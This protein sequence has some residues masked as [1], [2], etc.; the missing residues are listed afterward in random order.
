MTE[1]ATYTPGLMP[2]D[3]DRLRAL[4]GA[5]PTGV[6]VV[7]TVDAAGV[8]KGLTTQSF[9]AV[10]AEPP[11]VLVTLERS[12]RTL[13]P[14]RAAKA[15]VVNFLKVGAEEIA[16]RFASKIEDKFEGVAWRP[17][18]FARGAPILETA[19]VAYAECLVEREIEAGDHWIFIAVVEGGE[20]LG[21]T[22]LLYYHR[23]YAAWPQ[24]KP[25]P[26]ESW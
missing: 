14:L 13:E 2:V 23:A 19:C 26:P 3:R 12:S 16:T 4:R 22:P 5:F 6:T 8:P 9:V 15:F 24:E 25:A 17:S 10:S 7:T 18:R 1:A 21:D 11:I 20:V